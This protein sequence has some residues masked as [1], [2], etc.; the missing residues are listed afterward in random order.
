MLQV[1]GGVE[2]GRKE[3]RRGRC[4][5]NGKDA[6]ER[7]SNTVGDTIRRGGRDEKHTERGGRKR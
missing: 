5:T 7:R 1:R 2:E 4:G 3:T 6:V